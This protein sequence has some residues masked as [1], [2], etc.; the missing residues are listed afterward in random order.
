MAVL[1]VGRHNRVLRCQRLAHT[2]RDCLFADVQ[3]QEAADLSGA[4]QLH[5]SFLEP[6]DPQHLAQQF[7]AMCDVI[8]QAG[9]LPTR[10]ERH[11]AD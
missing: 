5:V 7:P 3:M 6:P 11:P 9:Q 1:T 10:A 8:G 2:D 4:V